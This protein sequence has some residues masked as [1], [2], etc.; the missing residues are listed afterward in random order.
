MK[1]TPQGHRLYLLL[2]EVGEKRYK[3]TIIIPD[4][5]KERSRIATVI[6]V[7]NEIKKFK[8]GDRVLVSYYCGTELHIPDRDMATGCHRCVP[9]EEI[10]F[11]ITE[12][13]KPE[14]EGEDEGE[15]EE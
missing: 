5:H 10:M 12:E 9:E 6:A 15:D 4:Q 8:A 14:V 2:D 11:K 7:G 3:D 13:E 1:L